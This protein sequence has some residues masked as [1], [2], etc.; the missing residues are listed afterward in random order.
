MTQEEFD[1]ATLRLSER[2]SVE[3]FYAQVTGNTKNTSEW[4]ERPNM[5]FDGVSPHKMISDGRF[6]EVM[7]YLHRVEHGVYT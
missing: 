1:L 5:W 7:D 2:Q 6:D 4:M 3:I